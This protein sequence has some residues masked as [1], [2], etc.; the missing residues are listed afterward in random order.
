[1]VRPGVPRKT[2]A[3]YAKKNRSKMARPSLRLQE[4]IK[5]VVAGT[6]ETKFVVDFPYN[7]QTGTNL[8]QGTAFT[9][10]ITTTNELYN[11]IPHLQIGSGDHQRIGNSIQPVSL[12]NTT[13]VYIPLV[14]SNI[15]NY[16]ANTYVDVFYLTSKQVKSDPANNEI[17]TAQLLNAGDGTNVPYDGTAQT[18][19]L[20]INKANFSLIAKKRVQLKLVKGDPNGQISGGS[21]FPP[22]DSVSYYEATWKLKIPLP[23][24]LIYQNDAATTCTNS[25]PFMCLG[26]HARDQ[27]GDYAPTSARVYCRSQSQMYYKDA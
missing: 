25:L 19:D 16:S 20:P 24:K 11:L 12:Y 17:P 5:K 3:Y 26:F 2:T 23:N 21:V 10:G 18:A 8:Y 27:N 15:T 22:N 14:G 6:Q 7:T 9:S 13:S 4:Q 1:M